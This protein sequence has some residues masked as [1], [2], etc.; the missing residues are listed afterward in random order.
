MIIHT[1]RTGSRLGDWL[2]QRQAHK[3]GV[4]TSTGIDHHAHRSIATKRDENH[5]NKRVG[6]VRSSAY[7]SAG[8]QCP[9]RV[10]IWNVI[11]DIST[12]LDIT[13]SSKTSYNPADCAEP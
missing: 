5:R 10:E 13:L 9:A 2:H 4:M 12:C 7:L 1:V 11:R 6:S 8:S 3:S